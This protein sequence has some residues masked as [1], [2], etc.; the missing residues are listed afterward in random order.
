MPYDAWPTLGEMIANN[1]RLVIF[2]DY[3]GADG[4]TVNY[5]IPEFDSVCPQCSPLPRLVDTPVAAR[6][7]RHLM[8]RRTRA[9]RARSTGSA[10]H[11]PLQTRCTSSTTTGTS[12]QAASSS[13]TRSTRRLPIAS[14]RASIL[15]RYSARSYD[16]DTCCFLCG[17][18]IANVNE[19]APLGSGRNPNFILF[20]YVDVG[21][22]VAAVN[23]LN[24]LT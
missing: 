19:C 1:Q 12:V 5:L 24:G 8:T 11:S 22:P 9:S 18:I 17:R 15:S 2:I 3:V 6:Y 14:H 21:S 7:G 20:D 23:Q 13:L 16:P 4:T 10:G